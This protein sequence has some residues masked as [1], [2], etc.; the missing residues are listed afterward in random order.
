MRNPKRISKLMSLLQ[1]IWEKAPDL[2]FFQL[3]YT[4]QEKYS[5]MNDKFGKVRQKPE[6]ISDLEKTGFDF[7]SL[8]DDKFEQFILENK[9]K[10]P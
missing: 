9:E 2:R 7:F 1:E 10:L 5:A 8:E 6:E 4:L 3:I